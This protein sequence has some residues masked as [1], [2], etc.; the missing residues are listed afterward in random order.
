MILAST[1]DIKKPQL[2]KATYHL[3]LIPYPYFSTFAPLR[4]YFIPIFA[5]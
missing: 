3:P 1:L 4:A 5:S 2:I